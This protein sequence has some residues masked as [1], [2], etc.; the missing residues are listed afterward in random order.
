MGLLS[1]TQA[2]ELE[3]S[4]NRGKLLL[5]GGIVCAAFLWA[6]SAPAQSVDADIP[7]P[8]LNLDA[9]PAVPA[10]AAPPVG[11]VDAMAPDPGTP[12]EVRIRRVEEDIVQE[13]SQGGRVYM[14]RVIPTR[15]LT[16]VYRDIDGDGRLNLEP[17]QEPVK[18]VYYTIYEWGKAKPRAG[19]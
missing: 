15:G 16:Q 13:Y 4:V 19:K 3:R 8:P 17:G 6:L 11:A 12:P 7:P 5:S 18:P 1:W 10:D 9:A 14:I 2:H